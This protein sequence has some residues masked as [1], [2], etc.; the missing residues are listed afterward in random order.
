MTRSID[1]RDL[2]MKYGQATALDHVSL[3]VEQGEFL[4]ILGPSGCGKSTLLNLIAGL[5]SAVQGE[6]YVGE[7]R[8][9]GLPPQKRGI[10]FVFQNY[11]LFPNMTVGENV[12]FGLKIR[13]AGGAVI[14]SRVAELL[15]IVNLQDQAHKKPNQLS[16]GQ[17]QRVALARALAPKPDILLLDEPLSA[18]DVKIRQHLRNE[19]KSLQR[20]LGITTVIVTHDQEEAFELGDRVAVM[21]QGKIVQIGDPE[22]IYQAP[23]TE[24]VA[25]FVGNINRLAGGI[26]NSQVHVAGLV[27]PLPAQLR[28]L[29]AGTAVI[30]LV[31]PENLSV[32]LA[33]DGAEGAAGATCG[34]ISHTVFL[35]PL[36]QLHIR[37]DEGQTVMAIVPQA[38]ARQEN[39]TAGRRVALRA[40]LYQIVR[41]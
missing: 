40:D 24:F 39:L 15:H 11:A 30:A 16:G 29:P 25:C 6:I 34:T 17:Q 18:L 1:V 12:A 21:E 8:I 23:A 3:L 10:G 7:Q 14:D 27:L 26:K 4:A 38:K 9:D 19:I 36:M 35:G 41:A 37:L 13:K 22:T 33:D 28:D 20:K 31:R 32:E 5:Q 2:T